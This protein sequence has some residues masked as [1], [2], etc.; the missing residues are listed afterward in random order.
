[1][2]KAHIYIYINSWIRLICNLKPYTNPSPNQ[3]P[4]LYIYIYK[5]EL[6][7]KLNLKYQAYLSVLSH[8]NE[9]LKKKKIEQLTCDDVRGLLTVLGARK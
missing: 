7:I 5:K 6:K 9:G 8:V 3:S 1:M 4:S 2:F